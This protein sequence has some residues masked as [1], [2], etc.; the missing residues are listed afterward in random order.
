MAKTR[1]IA[2]NENDPRHPSKA[3]RTILTTLNQVKITSQLLRYLILRGYLAGLQ[4]AESPDHRTA[5]DRRD[6]ADKSGL[7]R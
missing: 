7:N 2:E 1:T 3:A 5:I 4:L 6:I